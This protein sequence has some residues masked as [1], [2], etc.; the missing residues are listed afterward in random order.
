MGNI[1]PIIAAGGVAVVLY[2]RPVRGLALYAILSMWYPYA[3]GTLQVGTID[4]SVGRIV[5]VVL[6]AKILIGTDLASKFKLMWLDKL[7]IILFAAEI[8]AGLTT[9]GAME[10]IEYRMGDFF[11]MALPYFAVRLVVKSKDDYLVLLKTIA[12]SAGFLGVFGFYESLTGHNL[13]TLGRVL[14][15]LMR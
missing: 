1:T 14:S 7:V 6:L 9:T 4:F 8:V 13:L 3:V 15:Y 10:L 11:D 2:L 5:I 12:C